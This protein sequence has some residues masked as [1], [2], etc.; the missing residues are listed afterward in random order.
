MGQ[1]GRGGQGHLLLLVLA[2]GRAWSSSDDVWR[3]ASQ[4]GVPSWP[5]PSATTT[6]LHSALRQAVGSGVYSRQMAADTKPKPQGTR[7]DFD[8]LQH[9][10]S[11]FEAEY[12]HSLHRLPFAPRNGEEQVL[13][14]DHAIGRHRCVVR[15]FER[16]LKQRLAMYHPA[17]V[18][19]AEAPT[20]RPYTSVRRPG[21]LFGMYGSVLHLGNKYRMWLGEFTTFYTESEDGVVW[22]PLRKLRAD[23]RWAAQHVCVTHDRLRRRLLMGY[24]CATKGGEAVCVATSSE[25]DG[26]HWK[27]M[28][29]GKRGTSCRVMRQCCGPLCMD[30][31]DAY[32]CVRFDEADREYHLVKR[33]SFGTPAHWREIRGV[34]TARNGDI[35]ANL[36]AFQEQ[37]RWYL[38]REGKLERFQRQVYS[39]SESALPP[40]RP[41]EAGSNLLPAPDSARLIVVT[42]LEWPKLSF[43]DR[44]APSKRR[45]PL[46]RD[47]VQPYL[48]T[49]RDGVLWDLDAIYA[50]RALVPRGACASTVAENVS[51]CDF[52]HG[53]IQPA[54]EILTT[55]HS[56]VLFYEGRQEQHDRRFAAP[57]TIAAAR[58]PIY[59]LRGLH[60]DPS[61]ATARA[62]QLGPCGTQAYGAVETRPFHL[63][64]TNLTA[65]VAGPLSAKNGQGAKRKGESGEWGL[66][67]EVVDGRSGEPLPGLSWAESVPLRGDGQKLHVTWNETTLAHVTVGRLVKL[68]F[69]LCGDR[70]TLYSFALSNPPAP[71]EV[72]AGRGSGAG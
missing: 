17:L 29:H 66:R 43:M 64:S 49:S 7:V 3:Y 63:E 35:D 40:A 2:P 42:V 59:R 30:H 55:E 41:G 16:P 20:R 27:P 51:H 58:W 36:T 50:E 65:N 26:L 68:R 19:S 14:D 47:Y 24:R 38:D 39:S 10:T 46:T 70:T 72:G 9:C 18:K 37:R 15:G 71:S 28:H 57:A 11:C 6:Q 5:Q 69:Y 21:V 1:G 13:L 34:I 60:W 22:S 45:T 52:D 32:N 23:K 54:S 62:E 8:H 48:A 4:R 53:Y 67:A 31:A 12:R 56:H 61:C 44:V 33:G 25:S